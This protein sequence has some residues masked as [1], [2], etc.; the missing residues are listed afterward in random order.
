MTR[1]RALQVVQRDAS[2]LPRLRPLK[3][4]PPFWGDRRLWAYVRLA[5]QL[6][7]NRKRMLREHHLGVTPTLKLNAKR[8]PPGSK[9][10]PAKPSAWWGMEQPTSRACV[11]ACRTIGSQQAC[12]SDNN[13]KG[14]A[15]TARVMR[16]LK[17]ECR[18]FKPWA[19]PLA[20]IGALK[21]WITDDNEH[22]LPSAF[23]KPPRQ[24][25]REYLISR[26]TQFTAA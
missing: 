8:T 23:S 26:G 12:T 11:T 13:P 22:D 21:T 10:K 20:L 9:P 14:N 3:A 19:C 2:L 6:P 18:W 16:P 1:R 25:E 24:L 17:E 5:A 7:V 15:A 4:A